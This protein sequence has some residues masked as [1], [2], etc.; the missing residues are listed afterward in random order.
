MNH[1]KNEKSPYL[2]QHIN[3]PVDWYPWGDEAFE[4]AKKENKPIFLSIGYST[5]HWCHVMAH[6]S[7]EDKE[8]AALLNKDFVSV[9]VD[10]EERPDI[11]AVYMSVCQMMTG[12]GGWPLTVFLTPD[13]KPF[14]AGTY[15]PKHAKYGHAGLIEILPRITDIWQNNQS[16]IDHTIQ[17][18][19]AA[20]KESQATVS[21]SG[22]YNLVD[23][24]NKTKSELNISYDRNH[25]GFGV[26]PKFPSPQKLLFLLEDY[27]INNNKESLE[28][29]ENTLHQ[30]F[31]GG[32]FDH[33][34]GGFHRYSTDQEWRLPHF[35][36]MLYDQAWLSYAYVVCFELTQNAFYKKVAERVFDF[37]LREMTTPEGAFYS[38]YDAD[39]EGEEGKFYIWD[40]D[41]LKQSLS[42]EEF[43]FVEEYFDVSSDGNFNDE[44]S[45]EPTG[46]NVFYLKTPLLRAEPAEVDKFFNGFY[47]IR[48]KLNDIR[49]K[50]V[51]PQ[52]D[53]KILTDWNSL[54]AASFL[55]AGRT[56][57]DEKYKQVGL[58]N[59]KFITEELKLG[60]HLFHRICEGELQK[61]EFLDDQASFIWALTHAYEA[62]TDKS[63][64][65]IA[66]DH[67][68]KVESDF[69]DPS[70][71]YFLTPES[72]TPVLIRMKD[73]YDGAQPSANSVYL[74]CLTKLTLYLKAPPLQDVFEENIRKIYD[75]I[76][77][78]PSSYAFT[79]LSCLFFQHPYCDDELC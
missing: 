62:T 44:S 55:K 60:K 34:G 33:I 77:F 32:F 23:L 25:G 79:A 64:L 35:E 12:Q 68:D 29:V 8:V 50:R 37:V 36:K 63:Y 17:S 6:E 72:Q 67:I 76:S 10:R 73:F 30:M 27:K 16:E 54:M 41:S 7:F 58:K 9:K 39:S 19:Q 5:C 74:N 28:V 18:I 2:I 56:F 69:K 52:L 48:Q 4:K 59:I 57:D 75:Q 14:F 45:G 78:S 47:P 22:E 40:Y 3:N 13:Q 61:H 70:G 66:R 15:F 53:N 21:A 26:R 1:L 20:I 24:V 65:E 49:E 43:S 38:A 46:M 31:R 71:G 11:D 51:K 42:K